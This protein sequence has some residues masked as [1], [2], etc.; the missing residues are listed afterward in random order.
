MK[1]KAHRS[2]DPV[3]SFHRL[4][5]IF[6]L[7]KNLRTNSNETRPN[8]LAEKKWDSG[9]TGRLLSLSAFKSC[10]LFHILHKLTYDSTILIQN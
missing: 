7:S 3:A 5:Q 4:L 8:F 9:K 2:H 1:E 10:I 6:T